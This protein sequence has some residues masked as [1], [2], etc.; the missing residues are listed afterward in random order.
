MSLL[1]R[2]NVSF[3]RL[4]RNPVPQRT[5]ALPY[6]LRDLNHLTL[7]A[8][9]FALKQA[10]IA[11]LFAFDALQMLGPRFDRP[12]ADVRVKVQNFRSHFFPVVHVPLR[13]LLVHRYTPFCV[14]VRS[15]NLL[16]CVLR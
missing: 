16:D 10:V 15:S 7:A 14:P 6:V 13:W 5:T 1:V 12:C 11:R 9:A 3:A 2:L 4:K 8:F